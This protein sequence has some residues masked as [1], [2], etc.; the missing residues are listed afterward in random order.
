MLDIINHTWFFIGIILLILGTF[1]TIFDY[2][3]I[4]YFENMDSQMYSSLDSETKEIHKRLQI[5]LS[6]GITILLAGGTSLTFSLF[7]KKKKS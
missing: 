6:I 7:R 5:E 1:V 3:Q 4:Q 2:P